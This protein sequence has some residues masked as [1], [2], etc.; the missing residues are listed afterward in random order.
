[1]LVV[2]MNGRRKKLKKNYTHEHSAIPATFLII[3][4]VLQN[5]WCLKF[6]YPKQRT[7]RLSMY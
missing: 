2:K 6:C 5:L 4:I 1:M 7:T 3:I